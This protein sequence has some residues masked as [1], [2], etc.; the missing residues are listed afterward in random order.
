MKERFCLAMLCIGLVLL[1]NS[2]AT[3][4]NEPPVVDPGGPYTGIAGQ[5]VQFD[6][7]GTTDPDG[8]TIIYLWDFGD[9]SQPQFPS[10]DPTTSHAYGADGIYTVTLTVTD[11]VNPP[12]SDQ[13][14]VDIGGLLNDPPIADP[15]GPYTDTVGQPVQFDGSGSLDPDGTIISYDWDFGDGNTGTGVTPTHT[16]VSIGTYTVT[17]TVTD[18]DGATDTATTTATTRELVTIADLSVIKSDS[19]DPVMVDTNLIY[20]LTAQNDGPDTARNVVVTDALMASVNYVSND[21]GAD[22]PVGNVLTWNVGNLANGT[23][24][25]C[26]ITV[27]PTSVGLI[28]NQ[29]TIS[30]S[31]TDPTSDN[32]T[33]AEETVVTLPVPDLDG[34]GIPDDNDNCPDIPNIVQNDY[35]NDGL[36]DVCDNCPSD[37]NPKQLDRDGDGKGDECDL[38]PLLQILDEGSEEVQM[39]R[40]FRDNVLNQTLE[41]KQL[42]EVYYEWS[43]LIVRVLEEDEEFKEE[44]TEL[45]YEILPLIQGLLE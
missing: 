43:P 21:C 7:S 35:D 11:G 15:N 30:S 19:P 26:N 41:G 37:P 44:M 9:G 36:G 20:S 22:P 14:T 29:A 42:I 27:I 5:P 18:D 32:N 25:M 16:Y 33:V 28:I 40:D 31:T 10:Q 2:V 3:A 8:D 12:V 23:T 4:Q 17:L 24:A 45:I 13:T 6:A 34:D 39:F 38:C 1:F